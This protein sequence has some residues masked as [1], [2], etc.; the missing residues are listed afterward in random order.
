M[1]N[2]AAT[3]LDW[4]DGLAPGHS[5]GANGELR[6]GGVGALALAET[7][8]TPLLALDYGVLDASI[9]RF[10]AACDPLGVEI[11][12][13]GKALLLVGFARH[14]HSRGTNLDVCSLGELV[15]AERAGYP[16]ERLTF[17]G[18]GKNAAELQAVA[19]GRAG[20]IV[21]DSLDEL[22]ALAAASHG[23]AIAVLLRINTGIEAHTHDMVRTAGDR[24]KFG[25]PPDAALE[26][27]K[28]FQG[29][30]DLHFLGLHAHIGSQIYDAAPLVENARELTRTAV[31]FAAHGLTARVL[32]A[33]GGFGVRMSP[34][35]E[36]AAPIEATVRALAA[37]IAD[38]AGRGLIPAPA[39]GI[40]PGRA[41]VAEAGTAF[42][43]VMAVKEQF[44]RPFVV[45]DGGLADNPR[46]ALYG[47]YHHPVLASRLGGPPRET[48]VCGRSCESD[49][50]VTAD[51]PNDIVAGDVVAMCT[52]GAY[53]FSMSSNYNRFARPAVVAIDNAQLT[54][55][56]RRESVDD[57]LRNDCNA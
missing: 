37:G 31:R 22:R 43:R 29:A 55:L 4:R 36:P 8:D 41:I 40:E 12:Y 2:S 45:V 23:R 6:V 53:T 47:A 15:T 57:V 42:Y 27:A 13:A 38:E 1:L 7:Y 52:T 19:Q 48:V 51:L 33:G 24:S 32:V 49:Y 50:I 39:I 54:L 18:C 56:A 46:P 17:H 35:D 5:R 10:R 16:P 11:S 44:G 25:M 9:D 3:T 28:I 14:L 20:R 34:H 21:V 30:G 26:A